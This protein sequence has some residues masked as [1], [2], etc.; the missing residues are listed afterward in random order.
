VTRRDV[1]E[2]WNRGNLDVYDESLA[3]GYVSHDPGFGGDTYGR[4]A[5]KE[6]VRSFRAAAPDLEVTLDDVIAEADK[7]VTRWRVEGTHEGP[8]AGIPPTGRRVSITGITI[9]AFADGRIVESWSHWDTAGLMR[10][11]QHQE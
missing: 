1:I 3:D 8:L 11:L 6:R 7:V 9:D 4:A 5:V 10:Q 2:A